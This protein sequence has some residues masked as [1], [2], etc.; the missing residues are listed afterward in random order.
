MKYCIRIIIALC[1]LSLTIQW[2]NAQEKRERMII[3][4]KG[5]APIGYWVDRTD[6]IKFLSDTPDL[7]VSC[8]FEPI[9]GK[10]GAVK[11]KNITAGAEVVSI[12]FVAPKQDK[13]PEGATQEELEKI[14]SQT[15]KDKTWVLEAGKEYDFTGLQNGDAY[16]ALLVGIDQYGCRGSIKR[17]NLTVPKGPLK[18][19]PVVKVT[20]T[21]VTTTGYTVSLNPNQDVAKYYYFNDLTV[22][23]DRDAMMWMFGFTT[24]RDYVVA[25]GKD[26]KTQS[27]YVGSHTH[28]M[29]DFF[30][31]TEY[32]AF[33]VIEDADG[34]LSEV[35]TT[36]T[37]TTEKLGTSETAHVSVTVTDIT[38]TSAKVSCKPD[39]NTSKYRYLI[40]E[41]NAFNEEETS[42]MFKEEP[43]TPQFPY[44]IGDDS[45]TWETLK[46]GISYYAIAMAQNADGVWG[47]MEKVEFTTLAQ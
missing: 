33:V 26:S 29:K 1:L 21:D 16:A 20:F 6:S 46:P 35:I 12:Q 47:P 34:Q 39:V 44:T 37:V 2:G 19:N 38:A 40:Q 17:I 7:D 32:T 45:W 31:G 25:I 8:Q 23:P 9:A 27:G 43:D 18:G 3:Y 10:T 14:F 5:G 22:N 4:P 28:T 24:L 13:V 15:P 42:R 36:N 11:I 41:K 30:P